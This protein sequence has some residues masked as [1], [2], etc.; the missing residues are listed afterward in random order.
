MPQGLDPCLQPQLGFPKTRVPGE[1]PFK[2][3]A[4]LE[5]ARSFVVA[6]EAGPAGPGYC[7]VFPFP[8]DQGQCPEDTESRSGQK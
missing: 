8:K 7:P 3:N 6:G 1:A 5:P 4:A 2:G